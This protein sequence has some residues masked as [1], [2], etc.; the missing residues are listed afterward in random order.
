MGNLIPKPQVN[1]QNHNQE[2]VEEETFTC[3]ICSEPANNKFKNNDKCIH[4]FCTDCMFKYIQAKLDD[5]VSDIKC[6]AMICNHS[7]EP[8]S[9]RPKIARQLFDK[10]CDVLCES[11]VLKLDRVYCPNQECSELILNQC[12]E[13]NLKR[14]VCPNC[15]KPFCFWC[16][17]PW[18]AGYRCE[19]SGE[20]RDENDVAFG[21][22][23]ESKRWMRCPMCRH[24][25]E[26]VDGCKMVHCRCGTQFCYICG[27]E[28]GQHHMCNRYTAIFCWGKE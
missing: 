23:S 7:L 9:C 15:K 12:G 18:H 24:C 3:E 4:P 26:R 28:G 5:N 10:W 16:K 8:L 1:S 11:A 19:E 2:Q 22:L 17:V 14:C 13:N 27:K 6:P 25:V 21:V 20:T